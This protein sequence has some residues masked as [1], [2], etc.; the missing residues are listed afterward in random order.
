M[1]STC[2]KMIHSLYEAGGE[3]SPSNP[4]KFK[5]QDY[6]QLKETLLNEGRTFEDETFP[7]NLDSLGKVEDFTSEMLSEVEWFRPHVSQSVHAEQCFR[8]RFCV[9]LS[10]CLSPSIGT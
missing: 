9:R 4:V 7:A 8:K 10:K 5:G 1:T 3:G 6:K 2:V